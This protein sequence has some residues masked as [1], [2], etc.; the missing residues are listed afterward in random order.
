MLGWLLL[1][2]PSHEVALHPGHNSLA[3]AFTDLGNAFWVY[4]ELAVSQPN[5]VRVCDHSSGIY[6]HDRVAVLVNIAIHSDEL[7]NR[8]FGFEELL[9]DGLDSSNSL[10]GCKG[11]SNFHPISSSRSLGRTFRP[12][13]MDAGERLPVLGGYCIGSVSQKVCHDD[14]LGIRL[15]RAVLIAASDLGALRQGILPIH[16]PYLHASNRLATVSNGIV[17]PLALHLGERI[18]EGAHASSGRIKLP[19]G[20]RLGAERGCEEEEGCERV[21]HGLDSSNPGAGCKGS[22]GK[23]RGKETHCKTYNPPYPEDHCY[24]TK[25]KFKKS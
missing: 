17:L 15:G 19:Q 1:S 2:F 4:V 9:H 10:L 16:L 24:N 21:L 3:P 18:K 14:S 6:G 25:L 7:A 8:E 20:D 12:T 23:N 22:A 5:L 11:L 13:V